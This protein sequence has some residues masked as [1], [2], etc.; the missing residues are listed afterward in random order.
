MDISKPEV[1]MISPPEPCVLLASTALPGCIVNNPT[2]GVVGKLPTVIVMLPA[3]PP[4]PATSLLE[5]HAPVTLEHRVGSGLG[6]LPPPGPCI[7]KSPLTVTEM[8]PPLPAPEVFS[9]VIK[10]PCCHRHVPI[11]HIDGDRVPAARP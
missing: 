6:G 3:V 1:M 5:M 11:L 2:G 10:L 7:R 4:P 8:G 9:D